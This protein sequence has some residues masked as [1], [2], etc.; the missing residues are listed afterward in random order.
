MKRRLN[1]GCSNKD[2]IAVTSRP[3]TMTACRVV[4][5]GLKRESENDSVRRS[6]RS[7]DVKATAPEVVLFS[8]ANGM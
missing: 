7:G 4:E 3:P 1:G 6:S 8:E 2:W 5:I